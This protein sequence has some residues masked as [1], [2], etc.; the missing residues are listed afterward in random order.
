M[1]NSPKNICYISPKFDVNTHPLLHKF[2]P[3][4]II[5]THTLKSLFSQLR[6]KH[7]YSMI[8]SLTNSHT[9]PTYN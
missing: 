5:Y 9:E 6:M 7:I 2:A 3:F 4:T 8:P 1:Q